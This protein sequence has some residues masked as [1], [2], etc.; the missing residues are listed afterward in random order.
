MLI[1]TLLAAATLFLGLAGC[2]TTVVPP[3]AVEDPVKVFLADYGRH[4]SLVLPRSEHALVEYA[5]GEWRWFALNDTGFFSACRALG[6]ASEGTLGRR[7]IPIEPETDLRLLFPHVTLFELA[8]EREA[9]VLLLGRLDARWQ[10]QE[11]LAVFND[12]YGFH[13]V[14]DDQRYHLFR[15][16]NPIV[17]AWLRELGCQVR[18]PALLSNWRVRPLDD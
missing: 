9:V 1:L 13:F 2:A 10:R 5:F 6:W 15:N 17:A 12:N 16:C 7:T 4:S 3:R 14:P 8:V 11:E 18:A